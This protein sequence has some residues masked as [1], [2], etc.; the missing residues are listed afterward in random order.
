MLNSLRFD[1]ICADLDRTGHLARDILLILF[2]PSTA[3]RVTR[4]DCRL[5]TAPLS[6]SFR[7]SRSPTLHASC[8]PRA[9]NAL[10][11][12]CPLIP[13]RPCL[14]LRLH[15]RGVYTCQVPF[16]RSLFESV[17][18]Y[19]Y[20][21]RLNPLDHASVCLFFITVI[22]LAAVHV[23]L[24]YSSSRLCSHCEVHDR[25]KLSRMRVVQTG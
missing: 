23:W 18:I 2:L 20:P 3:T 4:P 14:L 24:V 22:H 9:H 6:S 13:H 15:L 12:R 17:F 19:I 11:N 5:N 8:R 16:L 21:T 25:E 1:S 10:S 7:S